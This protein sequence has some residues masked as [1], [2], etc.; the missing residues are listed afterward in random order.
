[1]HRDVKCENLLLSRTGQVKL[2]DFGLASPLNR[3][4]SAR[5]GTAKWSK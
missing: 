4:N 1:M 2:A 5:L 3:V